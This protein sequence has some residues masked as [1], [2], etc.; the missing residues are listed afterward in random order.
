MTTKTQYTA[1]TLFSKL[2]EMGDTVVDYINSVGKKRYAVVTVDFSTPCV[3]AVVKEKQ[4][5]ELI[6]GTLLTVFCWDAYK[7]ISLDATKILQ[8][9]PLSEVVNGVHRNTGSA[10]ISKK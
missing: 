4:N 7:L 6:K 1:E 9:T 3:L 8:L 2:E 5:M 10:N